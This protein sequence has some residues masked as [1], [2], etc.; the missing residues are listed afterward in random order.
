MG[1]IAGIGGDVEMVR[2]RVLVKAAQESGIDLKLETLPGHIGLVF[3]GAD[4]V[5]TTKAVFNLRKESKA[6]EVVGGLFEGKLFNAE[7]VEI[8]SKLPSKDE[9]RAQLLGTLVAPLTQTVAV[10]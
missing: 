7:D 5:Q 8:L 9:M 10:T 2:K 6:I 4:S 3:G 1:V